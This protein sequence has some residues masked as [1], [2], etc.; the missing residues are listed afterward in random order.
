MT[1]KGTEEKENTSVFVVLIAWEFRH[2]F[3]FSVTGVV[4]AAKMQLDDDCALMCFRGYS[5]VEVLRLKK[6]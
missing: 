5:R 4:A 3:F 2:T 1:R 6:S